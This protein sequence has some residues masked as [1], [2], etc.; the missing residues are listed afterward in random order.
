MKPMTRNFT[1]FAWRRL[2]LALPL[3]L[4]LTWP[5]TDACAQKAV[6]R[7]NLLYW[8]TGTPNVGVD[9]RLRPRHTLGL[10][11][12][13]QPW[14]YS[15]TKKLKHWSLQAEY[16]YWFCEAFNGHYLGA[17][18]L[19]GQYN[20]GGI[21][22]PFGVFPTLEDHR[23]QG[24][25]VGAGISWGYQVLLSRRWSLEFGIGLGYLY[26][27]YKKYR[28]P[29]CGEAIKDKNRHYVGPTKAAINLV[30]NF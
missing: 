23:Y 28:C 16:R 29:Q 9:F 30:Y 14:E 10:H 25:A 18:V 13:W 27:D 2:W 3:A 8:A 22:V 6:A 24:W 17:H 19:G 20:A 26:L 12:G 15:D 5:A 4:L 21:D 7:T 1:H 11:A